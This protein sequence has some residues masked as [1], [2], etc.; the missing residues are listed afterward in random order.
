MR[1]GGAVSSTISSFPNHGHIYLGQLVLEESDA[2]GD[3]DSPITKK[4]NGPLDAVRSKFSRNR[5]HASSARSSRTSVGTSDE[6]LARRAELKRLM[7]RRIQEEL[8]H[9][10]APS[11]ERSA[12]VVSAAKSI[13][14]VPPGSGPRDTLEFSMVD[15]S[16]PDD[17][18]S[19][20]NG[21]LKTSRSLIAVSEHSNKAALTKQLSQP[22]SL[23]EGRVLV[24]PAEYTEILAHMNISDP[25]ATPL[26][27]PTKKPSVPEDMS[28]SSL[29]LSPETSRCRETETPPNDSPRPKEH[30]PR[31]IRD[32]SS[33]FGNWLLVQGLCRS[34]GS[35]KK[36]LG[37]RE[38][39]S[40][41]DV[42]APAAKQEPCHVLNLDLPGVALFDEHGPPDQYPSAPTS[43]SGVL[44]RPHHTTIELPVSSIAVSE[45]SS[46]HE[47]EAEL[48]AVEK[49]FADVVARRVPKEPKSSKFKEEFDLPVHPGIVTRSSMLLQKLH[50]PVPNF[51]RPR[52][53]SS[54][55]PPTLVYY[56]HGV[57][58]AHGEPLGEN[59]LPIRKSV[60]TV[61]VSHTLSP[62]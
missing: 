24:P 41:V 46:Y 17:V 58:H 38:A 51:S 62:A 35:S 60:D 15:T 23:H 30:S 13:T 12:S 34:G 45:S 42:R 39:K 22:S 7:H 19:D 4:H 56:H 29:M 18:R 16:L 1:S 57:A 28:P 20:K 61:H 14:P 59:E 6:E 33:G 31:L 50:L 2:D 8:E 27:Q 5:L 36:Q 21:N 44:D 54:G 47:R 32:C 40:Q 37:P 43:R 10:D 9:E 3:I 49:R 52:S 53:R 11:N 25:P 26:L 55:Q 48:E